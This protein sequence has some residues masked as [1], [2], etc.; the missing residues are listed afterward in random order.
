MLL[1]RRIIFY[2][3][4][5]L[6]FIVCPVLLL[7]ALGYTINPLTRE[8]EQTG[9]IHLSTIPAGAS[10][11]LEHSRFVQKTPTNINE[12]HPGQ[13]HVTL[14]LPGYR[15]WGKQVAVS[16]GKATAFDKILLIPKDLSPSIF[17]AGTFRQLRPLT[18]TDFI[19]TAQD[20]NLGSFQ[21]H[22]WKTNKHFP[23]AD[24]SSA[25]Y[26]FPVLSVFHEDD[27]KVFI[28]YGGGLWERKY[29]FVDMKGDVPVISDITKLFSKDPLLIK[30]D[31]ASSNDLFPVYANYIDRIDVGTSAFY[32]RYLEDVKGCGFHNNKIFLVSNENVFTKY[33][34]EKTKPES[35]L[36]NKRMDTS[37]LGKN[38]FFNIMIY[39]DDLVFLQGEDGRLIT[40]S[41]PY[42]LMDK[43]VLGIKYHER[44]KS[45]LVWTA[46][47]V[48]S[49]KFVAGQS[50]IKEWKFR[51]VYQGG[52]DIKQCF[53]ALDASYVIV[54]DNDKIYVF[55]TEPVS[56]F[57]GEALVSVKKGSLIFYSNETGCVY[58]LDEAGQFRKIQLIPKENIVEQLLNK[59]E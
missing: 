44:S 3:L 55:E 46:G 15:T 57:H 8:V 10:V 31:P 32:P 13:Y 37:A 12:L 42:Q 43:G 5:V 1:L 4:V 38:V 51:Q 11:Y 18:G 21:L 25:W 22:N 28:L 50:G 52:E 39:P 47:A 17:M 53:W 33:D 34:H 36:E 59:D 48:F 9:L 26:G 7:F 45:L 27:S 54:N 29:L 49:A 6:Y 41:A 16:P 2:C 40:N 24:H 23:L 19:L 35:F 56:G 58:F 20:V 14:D 30:W